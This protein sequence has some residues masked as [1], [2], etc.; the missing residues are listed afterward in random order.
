MLPPVTVDPILIHTVVYNCYKKAGIEPAWLDCEPATPT[1]ELLCLLV[2]P[3][4]L[5]T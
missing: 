1:T 4:S 3:K 5:W 2:G